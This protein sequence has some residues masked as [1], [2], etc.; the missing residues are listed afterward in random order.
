MLAKPSLFLLQNLSNSP[1]ASVHSKYKPG[2]KKSHILEETEITSAEERGPVLAL[3][4]DFLNQSENRLMLSK[5]QK[6]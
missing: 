1:S 5:G 3:W 6:R 4:L 2:G